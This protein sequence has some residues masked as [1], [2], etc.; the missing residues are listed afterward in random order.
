[1]K[2]LS[3]ILLITVLVFS[4]LAVFVGCDKN[5]NDQ[6]TQEEENGESQTMI[7]TLY[8]H[9]NDAVLTAQLENNSSAKALVELLQNGDITIN[10]NDYAS[11]EKVGDLGTTL[12]RNDTNLTTAAGD[13]ILYLG[14][15][16]VIYY[17]TNSYSLTKL[18]KI[19]DVTQSELMALLGSGDVT[20]VLSLQK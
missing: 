11:F 4:M 8:I 7:N 3:S 19:K 20:I 9:V 2:K 17:D 15:Y 13:L 1:M 12:P 6:P 10:M 18:G 14:R 16:F 5:S